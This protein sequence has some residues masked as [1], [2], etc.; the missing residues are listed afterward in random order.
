[1]NKIM[2]KKILFIKIVLRIMKVIVLEWNLSWPSKE[3]NT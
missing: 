1:M 3:L 2:D